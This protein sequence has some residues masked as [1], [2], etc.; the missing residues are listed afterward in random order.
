[1][2][3]NLTTSTNTPTI[4]EVPS[5]TGFSA[6]DLVYYSGGSYTN[7]TNLSL[8]SSVN[9]GGSYPTPI[10]GS[11][12]GG[13][14]TGGSSVGSSP[15]GVATGST[16][17]RNAAAI[18]SNG[19][20][21][22]VY[23]NPIDTYHYF[24]IVTPAKVSVVAPTII[25]TSYANAT[26]GT[27][28]VNAL[29]GGGFV[30]Y[31]L[32]S[33]TIYP[34][35]AIYSNTGSSVTSA[36]QDTSSG[37][38]AY[39]SGTYPVLYGTALANGGFA[40][41]YADSGGTNMYLRAYGST[42][43][44]TYA[45]VQIA[46]FN[47]PAYGA[48]I[49][50]RSDSS[51]CVFGN[52]NTNG[53]FR[54]AIYNSTGTAI[55]SATNFLQTNGYAYTPQGAAV[56]CLSN[57][58]FVLAYN[59]YFSAGSYA[60]IC[61]RLLP[62][63]NTLGSEFYIPFNN[64]FPINSGL[65]VGI[66]VSSL[67]SGGFI[68]ASQV[69]S[70]YYVCYAVFNSSGTALSG[71]IAGS[72][73]TNA[74]TK[75]ID[76]S[77]APNSQSGFAT[78]LE[79]PSLGYVNVYGMGEVFNRKGYFQ[80]LS[81]ISLTTY[82]P[83][84]VYPTT[85]AGG[86][87]SATP[88]AYLTSSAVPSAAYYTT[89]TANSFQSISAINTVYK[90]G[91]VISSASSSGALTA[92]TLLNGN[93][94]IGYINASGAAFIALYNITGT[95]LTTYN[96]G[97]TVTNGTA[98]AYSQI[99][100]VT[101]TSG[102]LALVVGQY[103]TNTIS[104]YLF[105]V[106]GTTFTQTG[107]TA[108]LTTYSL[109]G[110]RPFTVSALTNDRIV[111][112]YSQSSGA[113]AAWAVYD[114]TPTQVA[115]ATWRS[116]DSH[117]VIVVGNPAGGFSTTAWGG[118]SAQYYQAYTNTSGNTFTAVG[119]TG[120]FAGANTMTAFVNPNGVCTPN[121]RMYLTVG[122]GTTNGYSMYIPQI[123]TGTSVNS[124]N[125]GS[126][127]YDLSTAP[128]AALGTTG[129]GTVF[130][131]Y[132]NSSSYINTVDN[133]GNQ[134][135]YSNAYYSGNT[136]GAMPTTCPGFGPYAVIAWL[137]SN[138]YPNYAIVCPNSYQYDYF[139]ATTSTPSV[140]VPIYPTATTATSPAITGTVFTGVAVTSAPAGGTGQVQISGSAQLNANYTTTT[141]SAFDSTGQAVPG[142]KGISNGR[143]III[144]GNT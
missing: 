130:M 86:T 73:G 92:A 133:L 61:F 72:G 71:T 28:G 13:Y 51:V 24:E 37:A 102:K 18:L 68:V 81:Q 34:C 43:T 39:G 62:T 4:I 119:S 114:N 20:I 131:V 106:S 104:I 21:V 79:V 19:N 40:L 123:T 16:L 116:S 11:G 78:L 5:T 52:T 70:F 75:N 88:N 100:L 111:I 3:R 50:A 7:G 55:V 95:L 26:S 59:A 142:V 15:S 46:G 135:T 87:A 2:S 35:Y 64:I 117:T 105:T 129:H 139:T 94:V 137:D 122:Y 115:Q 108:T 69:Q 112:G 42:G 101:M 90:V 141:V 85:Q 96:T 32:P 48:S 60:S 127:T 56:C 76:T 6:G 45:W 118:A 124:P 144:T 23:C 41:T 107:S 9:F 91:S 113:Y 132:Q 109:I 136:N 121:G 65:A 33:T 66:S 36:T 110:V 126:F 53:T 44:G 63:G 58:T 77:Y 49:A 8:P 47:N 134:A 125:Y 17:S 14:S 120:T 99:R 128:Q 80:Q 98:V 138:A 12:G 1:M 29:T 74:F 103:S 82:N 93:F 140:A 38:T 84:Y 89:A 83:V 31:W 97:L 143:N 30:V 25:T 10:M 22:Q 57:D 67:S 27:I 54:Y